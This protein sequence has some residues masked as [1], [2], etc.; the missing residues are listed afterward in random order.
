MFRA[1]IHKLPRNIA[2]IFQGVNLVWH[3]IAIVLTYFLVQSGFD[4]WY[5]ES[6]RGDLMFRL[7]LPAAILGFFIPII[8]PVSLYIFGE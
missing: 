7:T 2:G 3:I 6:T 5:F 8:V 1:F 4:W